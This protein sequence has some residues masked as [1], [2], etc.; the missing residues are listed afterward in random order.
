MNILTDLHI[1]DTDANVHLAYKDKFASYIK[2]EAKKINQRFSEYRD[3][4]SKIT[5]DEK[6]VF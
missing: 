3:R 1:Y 2:K 6:N 4:V 5:V